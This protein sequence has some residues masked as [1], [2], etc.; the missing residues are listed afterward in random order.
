MICRTIY[1]T[2]EFLDGFQGKITSTQAL[3][4]MYLCYNLKLCTGRTVTNC[5]AVIFDGGMITLA[6]VTLNI[7]H[8]GDVL[9]NP[10]SGYALDLTSSDK[11]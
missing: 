11:F 5:C 10:Q 4:S 7:F 8:P 1:R 2:A 3:F 6:M 9:Q